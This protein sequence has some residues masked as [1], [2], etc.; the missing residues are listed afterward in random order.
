MPVMPTYQRIIEDI[1]AKIASG[2]W[3]PGFRLPP[4]KE[5]AAQYA[6]RWR[7]EVSPQTVRRSTDTLQ[8][9]GVLAGRQGVAV[10]VPKPEP[11]SDDGAD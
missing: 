8:I 9:R 1:E 2:E 10:F 5:L 4:P 6:A 7:I 11:D 3:P